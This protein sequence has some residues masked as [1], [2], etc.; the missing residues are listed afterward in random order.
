MRQSVTNCVP[1][2]KQRPI[3]EL[4]VNGSARRL[5]RLVLLALAT[6]V[7]SGEQPAGRVVPSLHCQLPHGGTERAVISLA[8][9]RERP[10]LVVSGVSQ[11]SLFNKDPLAHYAR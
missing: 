3:G 2:V 5:Q 1:P 9:S 8:A 6:K 10:R 11:L 7:L 4:C